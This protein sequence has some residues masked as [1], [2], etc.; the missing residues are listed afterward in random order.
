VTNVL[1][2]SDH[3][4]EICF[5]SQENYVQ[6]VATQEG[7]IKNKAFTNTPTSNTGV[8]ISPWPDQEGNKLGSMSGARA[9]S[10]TSRRDLSSLLFFFLQ[11]KAPKDIR[12]I[13]SETLACFLPGRAKDLSV[14]L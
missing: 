1:T 5:C 11:G 10:A 2:Y 6:N 3:S 7:G 9:I 12:A 13:L 8:L 4:K 14:P